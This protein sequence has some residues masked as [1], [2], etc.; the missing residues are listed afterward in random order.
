MPDVSKHA[1]LLFF[2]GGPHS[3]GGIV[4]ILEASLIERHTSDATQPSF[5][6]LGTVADTDNHFGPVL[7]VKSKN[8]RSLSVRISW[9]NILGIVSGVD[10]ET[11][12]RTLGFAPAI[13]AKKE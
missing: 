11:D 13:R 9:Q 2:S 3:L 1:D 8:G 10:R 4:S 5:A 6:A 7:K 12:L